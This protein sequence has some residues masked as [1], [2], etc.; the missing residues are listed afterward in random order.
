M[1]LL[2]GELVGDLVGLFV[3]ERK[4]ERESERRLAPC[5]RGNWK[6]QSMDCWKGEKGQS[7]G[8]ELSQGNWLGNGWVRKEG[9]GGWE[10]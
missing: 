6:E 2:V 8:W 3:G 1:G 7:F 5:R 10:L 9:K 4:R